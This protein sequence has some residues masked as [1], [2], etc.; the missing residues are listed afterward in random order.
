MS[1]ASKKNNPFGA[2]DTFPVGDKRLGI[3]RLSK[4]EKDGLVP[5]LE[6]LPFSIRVLLEAVLRNCDGFSVTAEDV[7]RLAKWN[8][9]AP[10]PVELPFKPARVVLQD[11]TGV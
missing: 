2:R 1:T 11:F 8:A 4:L 9:P 7:K 10:E 6:K 3:Y 5:S